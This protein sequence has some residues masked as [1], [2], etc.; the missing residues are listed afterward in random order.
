[1]AMIVVVGASQGGVQ[2]L[3][4]LLRGLAPGFAAPVLMVQHIGRSQSILP[5]ILN[6]S[7]GPQAAF[8][9]H[10]EELAADRVYIAPPDHHMLVNGD[11]IELTRGPRENWARPAVDPLFRSAAQSRGSD[12]IGI[13]LTGR[14]N[15][16][17]AGLY[18][19]KRLGGIAMV[20][21]PGEAEAPAMPQSALD[22]VSV[23]YCLSVAEMP[24][25]LT[26]L[27]NEPSQ[28][29]SPFIRGVR[30]MEQQQTMGRPSAQIC[31]ECG[32]AMQE[33]I[34]ANLT[35]FRCHIGHVMTAEVLA[36]SQLD[37]LES[38]ISAV[39][40][41]LKERAVLCRDIASGHAARQS[42]AA[43]SWK[44]AADQAQGRE[45]AVQELLRAEWLHPESAGVPGE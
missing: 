4:T 44:Q 33:E 38:D 23:D 8:A 28:Q 25:L 9:F 21:T 30:D 27:V 2:A 31:P 20:Q 6:D 13:V 37:E 7:G 34:V 39:L 3:R 11:H 15:D 42:A 41:T 26:R 10:G 24:R 5:S 1:M 19:I 12:V 32:G 17:T 16:G 45:K 43:E 22:N 18:E 35:R 14:L 29:R 40:R 36:A